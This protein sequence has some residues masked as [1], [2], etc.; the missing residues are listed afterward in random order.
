MSYQSIQKEYA[1][2]YYDAPDK[3]SEFKMRGVNWSSIGTASLDKTEEF[4]KTI[5]KLVKEGR[6]LEKKFGK[7]HRKKQS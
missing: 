6:K 5:L 3:I 1:A 2:L 7:K 4:A